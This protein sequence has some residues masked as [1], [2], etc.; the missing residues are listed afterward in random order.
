MIW[1]KIR[2]HDT[3]TAQQQVLAAQLLALVKGHVADLAGSPTASRVIQV[4]TSTGPGTPSTLVIALV[5]CAGDAVD[6]IGCVSLHQDVL[7]VMGI[8]TRM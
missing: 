2:R 7:A 1:E 8:T 6:I 3:D 5:D 4:G